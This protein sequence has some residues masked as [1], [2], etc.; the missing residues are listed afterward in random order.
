MYV[1]MLDEKDWKKL[2]NILIGDGQKTA[3]PTT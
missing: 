3:Q 1:W 2:M